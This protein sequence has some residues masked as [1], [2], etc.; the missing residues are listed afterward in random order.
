MTHRRLVDLGLVPLV[1]Y[2]LIVVGFIGLSLFLFLKVE[3]APYIYVLISLF[4]TAKLSGT[5]RNDFLK[6]WF[7]KHV[8]H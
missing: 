3:C 5:E 1:S 4:I 7:K 6:L 8:H 2:P